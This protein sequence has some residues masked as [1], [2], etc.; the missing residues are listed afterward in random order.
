[1]QR[2][3]TI[4]LAGIVGFLAVLCI[5]ALIGVAGSSRPQTT[6]DGGMTLF[7][8]PNIVPCGNEPRACLLVR[9]RPDLPWVTYQGQIEGFTYEPGFLY[10]IHV[11]LVGAHPMLDNPQA[12]VRLIRVV[13]KTPQP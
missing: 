13:N 10:E 11:A 6:A 1:M 7:V 8:A 3:R 4:F 9:H 12:R 2:Q 5:A